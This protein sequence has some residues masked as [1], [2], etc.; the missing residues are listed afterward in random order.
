M[1]DGFED[2]GLDVYALGQAADGLLRPRR[3]VQVAISQTDSLREKRAL[4]KLAEDIK[5]VRL[6]CRAAKNRMAARRRAKQVA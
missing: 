3:S 6:R 2:L 5:G 4:A 1:S